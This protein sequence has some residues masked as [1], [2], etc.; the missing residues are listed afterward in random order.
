MSLERLRKSVTTLASNL[1]ELDDGEMANPAWAWHDYSGIRMAYLGSTQDLD[2]FAA[3]LRVFR[4]GNGPA[5]TE[6]QALVAAHRIAARDLQALLL[7]IDSETAT[8]RPGPR[9]WHLQRTLEHIYT[10]EKGFLAS[11]L[12]GVDLKIPAAIP[13]AEHRPDEQ[14]R[15]GLPATP[16][17]DAGIDEWKLAYQQLHQTAVARLAALDDSELDLGSPFWE[18]QIPT[19]RFRI[20]RL[21]AHLHEHT[22]QIEKILDVVK[23]PNEARRHA[24]RLFR[25]LGQIE[26][27]LIGAPEL[28]ARCEKPAAM[29]EARIRDV[30]RA[31]RQSQQLIEAIQA[32]NGPRVDQLTSADPRLCDTTTSDGVS[33]LL[34]AVYYRQPESVEILRTRGAWIG[35]FEATAIG[36]TETVEAYY[37]NS[38]SS[39]NR[40]A[41]DGYTPLQLAAFFNQP[42]MVAHLL[43][44]GA[45]VHAV[46][47]N[48]LKLQ[49]LHAA[50][51]GRNAVIVEA[52][53]A[54]GADPNAEQAGGF[55]P[56]DG[57]RQNG[58]EAII[59]LLEK[60]GAV[61]KNR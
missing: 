5:L 29:L 11:I 59:S 43:K 14:I 8:R 26:S 48:D 16:T 9:D 54:A 55:Q 25:A 32:G 41:E 22:I 45:D 6:A 2:E 58:D 39:I 4:S 18:E 46:S 12:T 51:A 23:P 44:L 17:D 27:I 30:D 52:L 53:L 24:R 13:R 42:D 47:R 20:G 19:V 57:A 15:D 35:L 7:D 28:E 31:R 33:A 37:S 38:A 34:L 60:A 10:A 49:S 36:D 21:T 40:F 3:Q 1:L 50:V 56:L 61:E